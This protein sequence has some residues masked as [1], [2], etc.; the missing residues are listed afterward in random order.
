[1][2]NASQGWENKGNV[3]AIDVV[4]MATDVLHCRLFMSRIPPHLKIRE[5]QTRPVVKK[6]TEGDRGAPLPESLSPSHPTSLVVK[7]WFRPSFSLQWPRLAQSILTPS[8]PFCE[9]HLKMYQ[10][11]V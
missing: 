3:G 6:V 8:F 9:M 4:P 2:L 7:K 11:A 1:M 5:T 10:A